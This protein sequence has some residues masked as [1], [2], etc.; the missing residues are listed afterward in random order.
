MIGVALQPIVHDEIADRKSDDSGDNDQL[1]VF[2]EKQENDLGGFRAY[3][4]PDSD[5]FTPPFRGGCSD[6]VDAELGD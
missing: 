3:Y 6:G 5:L 4:F 1:R 2:P